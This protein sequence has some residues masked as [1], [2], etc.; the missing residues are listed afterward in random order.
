[1]A[2]RRGGG[3]GGGRG[4]GKGKV[5]G[6]EYVGEKPA[7]LQAMER[8]L[9]GPSDAEKEVVPTLT[10]RRM[11]GEEYVHDDE[12]PTV[13]VLGKGDL[14]QEEVDR[15]EGRTGDGAGAKR[16]R[17]VEEEEEDA[18]A[19]KEG[20]VIFRASKKPKPSEDA[21]KASTYYPA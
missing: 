17:S 10:E 15:I 14:T 12:R 11:G 16:I 13:V 5:A 8:K 6:L 1:M 9:L 3:G 4:G 7:F 19:E 18:K 21:A 2:S 20:R